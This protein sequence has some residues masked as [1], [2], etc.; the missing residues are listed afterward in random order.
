MVTRPTDAELLT[1]A[2]QHCTPAQVEAL[3]LYAA[4][5]G[6]RRIGRELDISRQAA[7]QRVQGALDRIRR[8]I[9]QEEA[10]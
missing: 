5:K 3:E 7:H 8:H 9:D 1:L 2:R 10:A 4:G 6:Y